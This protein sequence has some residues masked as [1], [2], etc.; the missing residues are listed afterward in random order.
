MNTATYDVM[1][2]GGG[3]AGSTA[4]RHLALQGLRVGL[5][6]KETSPRYKPCGGVLA[7]RIAE[8]LDFP[9]DTVIEGSISEILITV[10]MHSPFRTRCPSP[11]AFLC[12]RDQ[13]DNLLLK[14]AS[15]A[16]VDVFLDEALLDVELSGSTYELMTSK[17]RRTAQ[18]LVAADG[19]NSTVRSCL[20]MP[21]FQRTSV[22]YQMEISGDPDLVKSWGES[23]ALDFGHLSSGYAWLFPKAD[24]FS[25]GAGGTRREARELKPYCQAFI[26][27]HASRIGDT[28]P[29]KSRGHP[30]PTRT[31]G[32][33]I[34]ADRVIFI[35]DAAGLVD[36]MTGEGIYYAIRSALIAAETIKTAIKSRDNN[37]IT[38]QQRIDQELQP[39]FQV[40]RTLLFLLDLAPAYWVPRLMNETHPFW[41]YFHQ[42][43]MGEKTYQDFPDN[44][45]IAGRLLFAI[46]DSVLPG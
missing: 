18:F 14:K 8:V 25:I 12:M 26:D 10:E 22:A 1:V 45:G 28:T 20:D 36:P 42:I 9:I 41:H 17:A 5:L 44:F 29:L 13:F 46:L 31:R 6:E 3:P 37:L 33:P 16:G 11:F 40:A 34:T 23:I 43:F 24:H 39:E 38:Y 4:A 21:P 35:G 7:R 2:I 19:A 27:F 15:D 32:E 30:V